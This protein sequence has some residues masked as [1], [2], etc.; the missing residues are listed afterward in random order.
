MQT[1]TTF[2]THA[3]VKV[4]VRAAG[5]EHSFHGS[6]R[7]EHVGAGMG[8][9]FTGNGPEH[10]KRIAALIESLSALGDKL[11]E[12]KVEL[13]APDK[14]AQPKSKTASV[15]DSLLGLMLVGSSLKRSDFLHEL[16]KQRRHG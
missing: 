13:A 6:V 5:A 11:P 14:S 8:I 1:G 2:P 3:P 15:A 16:E 10:E 7:V 9:E 12:V 4:N